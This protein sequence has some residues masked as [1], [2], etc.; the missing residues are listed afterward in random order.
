MLFMDSTMDEIAVSDPVLM[1]IVSQ[2][3]FCQVH[4]Q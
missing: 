4:P 3:Q 2:V 1:S